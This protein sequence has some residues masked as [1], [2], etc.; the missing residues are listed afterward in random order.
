MLKKAILPFALLLS[1][2]TTFAIDSKAAEVDDSGENSE[3]TPV[4]V[5]DLEN[6]GMGISPNVANSNAEVSPSFINDFRYRAVNVTT[7]N[8][9]SGYRRVS[10]NLKTG[11]GGGSISANKT[12]TFD[13][14]VS[15]EING[16]GISTSKSISSSIGYTLNVAPN[17]T[18]YMGYRVYYKVEKGTREYY[19]LVTG[20]VISRN[21][22]T[23]KV[24]QYGEYKLITVNWQLIE[25]RLAH[26]G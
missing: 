6:P 10:D 16:L 24:P 26:I 14:S 3:V 9:W 11:K 7:S 23:V 20:K 21:S 1:V 18:V 5:S 2:S 4:L 8:E 17:T 12:T 25:T 13:T 15:G 22:Y 19:D